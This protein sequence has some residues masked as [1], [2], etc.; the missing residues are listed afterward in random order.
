MALL[1]GILIS[2]YSLFRGREQE[3]DSLLR[4]CEIKILFRND[5][6]Q[7]WFSALLGSEEP[8]NVEGMVRSRLGGNQNTL[9]NVFKLEKGLRKDV[10][11]ES[12]Y[13]TRENPT[14]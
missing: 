13:L 9:W 5:W 10:L 12:L 3:F 7:V 6:N 1:T 14:N 2:Y 11:K 4:S 8:F